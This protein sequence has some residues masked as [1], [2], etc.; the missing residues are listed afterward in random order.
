MYFFIYSY[1]KFYIKYIFF[2]IFKYLTYLFFFFLFACIFNTHV[3]FMQ[4]KLQV[5]IFDYFNVVDTYEF[6][7]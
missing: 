4:I 5:L 7:L 3:L 6:V 2:V 1:Y